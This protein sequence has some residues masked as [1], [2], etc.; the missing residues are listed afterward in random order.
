MPVG[1][2]L[3]ST[4]ILVERARSAEQYEFK[5]QLRSPFIVLD[6]SHKQSARRLAFLLQLSRQEFALLELRN[7]HLSQEFRYQR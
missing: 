3:T 5:N 4:R 7:T 1:V 2:N 6:R